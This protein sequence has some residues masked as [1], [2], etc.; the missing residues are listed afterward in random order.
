MPTRWQGLRLEARGMIATV[1]LHSRPNAVLAPAPRLGFECVR[2]TAP[3]RT[4]LG[5]IRCWET[6]RRD[7][8]QPYVATEPSPHELVPAVD[9]RSDAMHPSD[10]QFEHSGTESRT[11]LEGEP[12]LQIALAIV[13]GAGSAAEW[14]AETA[15]G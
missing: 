14:A 3:L 9:S 6:R 15:S 8:V 13:S 7:P 4:H 10:S 2:C 5:S 1:L 12:H 11:A